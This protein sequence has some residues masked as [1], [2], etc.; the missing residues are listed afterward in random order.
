LEAKECVI[1]G[2]LPAGLACLSAKVVQYTITK[3][4]VMRVR[5][6]TIFPGVFIIFP[7]DLKVPCLNLSSIE[8]AIHGANH[9]FWG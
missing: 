4:R 1:T 2:G 6:R 8:I 9:V 7:F 5:I 3:G